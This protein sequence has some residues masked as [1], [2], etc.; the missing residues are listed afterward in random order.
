MSDGL[1]GVLPTPWRASRHAALLRRRPLLPLG[2]LVLLLV[3]GWALWPQLFSHVDP[4]LGVPAHALQGPSLEHWFG[5]DHLGRD[6]YS[7]TVHGAAL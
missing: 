5:T 4:L 1:T 7:R 3:V 2:V 6:L